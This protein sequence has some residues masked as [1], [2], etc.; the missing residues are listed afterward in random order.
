VTSYYAQYS[1][2]AGKRVPTVLFR[3]EVEGD[4]TSDGVY[5]RDGSWEFMPRLA[6]W[7]N[8]RDDSDIEEI[9]ESTAKDIIARAEATAR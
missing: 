3:R 4:P 6:L 8:G 5:Q 2:I 7:I 1:L 9:D